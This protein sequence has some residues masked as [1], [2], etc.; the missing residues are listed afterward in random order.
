MQFADNLTCSLTD[1][2]SGLEVFRLLELF[3]HT[4]GLKLNNTKSEGMWLGQSQYSVAKTF[5]ILLPEKPIRIVGVYVGHYQT[6]EEEANFGKPIKNLELQLNLWKSRNLSLIGKVLLVKT[7][8]ISKS[9]FLAKVI[10]IPKKNKKKINTTIYNFIWNG[11]M[12]KVSRNIFMQSYSNGGYNMHDFNVIDEVTK[13]L[14]IKHIHDNANSLWKKYI[15]DKSGIGNTNIFF[16]CNFSDYM[17]PNYSKLSLFYKEVISNWKVVQ[18][19]NT[20]T[21]DEKKITICLL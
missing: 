15:R 14:W 5:G 16:R 11:K 1:I 4:S 21:L 20:S 18:Y 2:Q 12:D 17:I 10:H 9:L 6:E 19:K 13:V 3:E 7:L 8:G